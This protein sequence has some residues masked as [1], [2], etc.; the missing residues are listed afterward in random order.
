MSISVS[1]A[2]RRGGLAVLRNRGRS[3]YSEIGKKGQLV[4]REKYPGV[5]H[6]W[7]KLGGRPCKPILVGI[8]RERGKKTT[9][10]VA[11][12]SALA[13]LPQPIISDEGAALHHG[14]ELKRRYDRLWITE[15]DHG[16]H[17]T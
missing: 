3:F 6:E 2:G 15:A 16:G 17:Q 9:K 12:P 1:E 10:E 5:A 4:M 14:E 8:M 7:G 11:D 13:S